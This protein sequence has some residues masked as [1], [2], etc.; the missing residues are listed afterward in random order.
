MS[1]LHHINIDNV[2][3]AVEKKLFKKR[4]IK[5]MKQNTKNQIKMITQITVY[6]ELNICHILFSVSMYI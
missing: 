6:T 4:Y 1:T 5:L 3:S 2:F